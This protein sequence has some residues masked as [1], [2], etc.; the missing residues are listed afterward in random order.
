MKLR[1]FLGLLAVGFVGSIAWLL[2]DPAPSPPAGGTGIGAAELSA[3][4]A[5]GQPVLVEFYADWCPPCRQVAPEVAKL[6]QE[7]KGQANVLKINVDH[8]KDLA[9]RYGIRAI[10]TFVAF[11]QGKESA[12][13]SGAIS[14]QAMRQMLGM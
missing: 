6:A 10:P 9:R 12:R 13:Q 1:H 4:L 2:Y 11:H 8:H 5:G 3:A 14:P 7:M